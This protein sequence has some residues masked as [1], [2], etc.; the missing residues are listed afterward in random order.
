MNTIIPATTNQRIQLFL[1]KKF[2]T[3]LKPIILPIITIVRKFTKSI[4]ENNITPI[5]AALLSLCPSFIL[6]FPLRKALIF[7][8]SNPKKLFSFCRTPINVNVNS[9]SL[10]WQTPVFQRLFV[11]TQWESGLLRAISRGLPGSRCR[12]CSMCGAGR[13]FCIHAFP[14]TGMPR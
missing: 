4:A 2:H 14:C 10:R 12:R 1:W 5:T 6:F 9:K 8:I 13:Q 3:T 11:F 7:L